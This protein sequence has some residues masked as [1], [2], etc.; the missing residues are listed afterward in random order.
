MLILN[1]YLYKNIKKR[2]VEILNTMEPAK[3]L[4]SPPKSTKGRLSPSGK[5]RLS[6]VEKEDDDE[7]EFFH[8]FSRDKVKVL[9]HLI[10]TELKT[11]GINTEYL[12]LPF[13]P[14]QTNEKLLRFLNQIFPLGNG[15]PVSE[16]KQLKYISRT[17]S[18]TLFQCLKYIW[19]RLPNGEI[20][21]WKAYKDFKVREQAQDFPQRSFLEIMPKCLSSPNHASIV[22]DF[23]DLIV[24]MASNSKQNKMSARKISKMCAVWAFGKTAQNTKVGYDFD[25]NDEKR[26]EDNNSFR[27]GLDQWIPA[28]DAMFHLLLSFIRSFVSQDLESANLPR[29]LKSVLFNSEY[30]PSGSTA[31]SSETILTVPL[32]SLHT[33][34]FSRKPW[35]LIERCNELFDF[36]NHDAF[37]AREDYALLKSLFKK[38][39]N[40]E[41]IS[42]KMSKESKRLMKEMSTKHSTFQAGWAGRKCLPGTETQSQIIVKRVDIDDYFIWAWLSTLSYEQTS[43]KRKIF[44]RS[45]ILEFEFDGFK[46]WVVLEECDANLEIKRQKRMDQIELVNKEKVLPVSPHADAEKQRNI[47]PSYEKFQK[48]N[49]ASDVLPPQSPAKYHTVI[50]PHQRE[51]GKSNVSIHS[52]EQKISKWNPLNLR[53][54]SNGSNSTLDP[55]VPN[56]Q[57]IPSHDIPTSR[58]QRAGPYQ[59]QQPP[60]KI[61][62]ETSQQDK[63]VLSAYSLLKP[64]EYQL[65]EVDEGGYKIELPLLD[66]E[67]ALD[68]PED[69][70]LP[71]LPQPSVSSSRT[72]SPVVS[73]KSGIDDLNDMV[74]ELTLQVMNVDKKLEESTVGATTTDE[75]FESLTMYDKYKP[76]PQS[77]VQ[78]ER[79]A[80]L[81]ESATSSVIQ[82]LR[83]GNQSTGSL[84]RPSPPIV[85]PSREQSPRR[86]TSP[87]SPSISRDRAYKQLPIISPQD[88]KTQQD[89]H[90]NNLK[91]QQ[92]EQHYLANQAPPS[93]LPPQDHVREPSPSHQQT[94]RLSP[95]PRDYVREPSPSPQHPHKRA[96]PTAYS[97]NTFDSNSQ[98]P[99]SSTESYPNHPAFQPGQERSKQ[100]PPGP[101]S[102]LSQSHYPPQKQPT[103]RYKP[104]YNKELPLSPT[105]ASPTPQGKYPPREQ[106]PVHY[107]QSP[108][109]KSAKLNA[110]GYDG[111]QAG[112]SNDSQAQQPGHVRKPSAVEYRQQDYGVPQTGTSNRQ[113]VIGGALPLGIFHGPN[114]ARQTEHPNPNYANQ[115]LSPRHHSPNPVQTQRPRRTNS[116]Q[117]PLNYPPQ[118]YQQMPSPKGYASPPQGYAPPPQGYAPPPQGY[119]PPP[120]GYAPPP[121]SYAP[122]LPP[123][124][125]YAASP[126]GRISPQQGYPPQPHNYYTS[127]PPPPLSP[128]QGFM[129]SGVPNASGGRFKKQTL[130]IPSQQQ[131]IYSAPGAPVVSKLHSGNATKQKDRKKLYQDIRSGNFG[132]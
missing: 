65:P 1:A 11:N 87:I 98:K 59:R 74:D 36:S 100:S 116:P 115:P 2:E 34:K 15:S 99:P 113:S 26:I 18:W 84:T 19:C 54:K 128:Q 71:A 57:T 24:M 56:V 8:E 109:K 43:E 81:E 83:L 70:F 25:S 132:I 29:A 77:D 51:R 64:E 97:Q 124:Q 31:Y 111:Q 123:P 22:Y 88:S 20:I 52:L 46:K 4:P 30:P 33:N 73:D 6:K 106:F 91:Q 110:A 105:Q 90:W 131:Q 16:E 55:V 63:R 41:G 93:S 39:N 104:V 126:Q 112:Y 66:Q 21:G 7:F 53:K 28:S 121:Q 44:G 62:P 42:R 72:H 79:R 130:N 107:A 103:P 47:T 49:M 108:V 75:T 129:P 94:T 45:L 125:G 12:F 118:G 92:P 96:E 58:E 40:V 13:R 80:S 119:A 82:P 89:A 85:S 127:P 17:D 122:P 68:F 9:I 48:N 50:R 67:E 69:N 5:K 3:P 37:E 114:P 86:E 95:S 60:Q 38:K 78:E 10:T 120:Q 23:F 27:E 102:P 14:E 101:T 117:Q 61:P 35:Q 32:V 76:H